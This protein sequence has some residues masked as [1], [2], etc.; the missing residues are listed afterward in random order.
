MAETLPRVRLRP[1]DETDADLLLVWRNDPMTRAMSVA[2]DLVEPRIHQLWLRAR[3]REPRGV[4]VIAEA[5]GEPV[6]TIRADPREQALRL[7]WTVAPEHRARGFGTAMVGQL[8]PRLGE[9]L[10][11]EIRPENTASRRIAARAGLTRMA[12]RHGMEI[13]VRGELDR[14]GRG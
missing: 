4:F 3:L 10:I 7:S 8:V 5:D 13:W 2:R 1:V 14:P 11:A 9:A 6:G 12:E